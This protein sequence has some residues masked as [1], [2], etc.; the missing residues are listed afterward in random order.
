MSRNY[1]LVGFDKFRLAL[2]LHLFMAAAFGS[3][4]QAPGL[5]Y[6]SER[7]LWLCRSKVLDSLWDIFWPNFRMLTI[8]LLIEF[9]TNIIVSLEF[10]SLNIKYVI[11]F[12]KKVSDS[13]N[14]TPYCNEI[15]FY[16]CNLNNIVI[17]IRISF[18][19]VF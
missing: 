10:L 8:E 2:C 1:L 6:G 19:A 16:I 15:Y 9:S 11:F 12:E 5:L 4:L 17:V 3:S 7:A 18:E 14:K 13:F